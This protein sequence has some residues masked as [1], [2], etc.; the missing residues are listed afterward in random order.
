MH[1][2]ILSPVDLLFRAQQ[3]KKCSEYSSYRLS[4]II[5]CPALLP[6]LKQYLSFCRAISPS[7][8]IILL[9][10]QNKISSLLTRRQIHQPTLNY[11]IPYALILNL[12]RHRR[13][14]WEQILPPSSQRGNSLFLA[15]QTLRTP[16]RCPLLTLVICLFLQYNSPPL[17]KEDIF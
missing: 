13:W 15:N 17:S 11:W 10:P 16:N 6:L 3:R 5:F 8:E 12:E 1:D 7:L 4:V 9:R 14:S 2:I